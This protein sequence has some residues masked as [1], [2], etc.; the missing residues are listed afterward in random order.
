M[1]ERGD[2]QDRR[3]DKLTDKHPYFQLD[4][5]SPHMQDEDHSKMGI[6]QP[7]P[8]SHGDPAQT[9]SS[10]EDERIRED[11][12]KRL[13]EHSQVDAARI[14][15]A[16]CQR[17]VRLSGIAANRFVK[18]RAEELAQEAEGVASVR[19]EIHIQP[20]QQEGGPI[21]TTHLPGIDHGSSN[22][23]S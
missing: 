8:E 19:N 13:A 12:R 4:A 5:G 2:T 15:V 11:I 3:L 22:Q 1:A 23:R 18:R 9:T 14:E 17:D 7:S 20:G 21:L 10:P 6:G 16:V